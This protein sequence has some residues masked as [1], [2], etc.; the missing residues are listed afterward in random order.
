ME[1]TQADFPLTT[2]SQTVAGWFHA[3]AMRLDGDKI[4]LPTPAQIAR[5]QL[6]TAQI[7]LMDAE[8]EAE[9]YAHTAQMLRKRVARLT[10]AQ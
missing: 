3:I 1:M 8:A 9:R 7:A 10:G 4:E 5:E 2:L 6:R